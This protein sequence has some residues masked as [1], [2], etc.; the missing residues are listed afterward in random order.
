MTTQAIYPT[1]FPCF[2]CR[3]RVDDMCGRPIMIQA[4]GKTRP[5]CEIEK[6]DI[7]TCQHQR[8]GLIAGLGMCGEGGAFF[9]PVADVA[10]E[11]NAARHGYVT[12]PAP[13]QWPFWICA[14]A[15]LAILA[16]LIAW[17]LS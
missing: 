12:L 4:T 1:C 6:G 17:G 5:F 2:Y 11:W 9:S 8:S 16:A 15:G 13:P 10:D 7:A 14:G 3:H